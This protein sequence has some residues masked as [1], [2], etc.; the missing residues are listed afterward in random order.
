MS[1]DSAGKQADPAP[2]KQRRRRGVS[3]WVA[4]VCIVILAIPL[5]LFFGTLAYVSWGG[6]NGS[7]VANVSRLFDAPARIGTV[8]TD[9]LKN[10]QVNNVT[11]LGPDK[12]TALTVGD[13]ILDWD[14]GAFLREGR[15]RSA[16]IERPQINLRRDEQGRWNLRLKPSAGKETYLV[17]QFIMREGDLAVEWNVPRPGPSAAQRGAAGLARSLRLQALSGTYADQGA[18]APSPFTLYGVFDS[19]E[20]VSVAGSIGPDRSWDGRVFGGVKLE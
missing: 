10:L 11:V 18:R 4:V 3:F 16:T 17:E 9:W 5:I 12:S 7:I 2:V 15:I 14:V 1:S 20:T 19:L 6:L 8:R 13:L